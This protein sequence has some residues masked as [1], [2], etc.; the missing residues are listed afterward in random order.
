MFNMTPPQRKKDAKT[1]Q[2]INTLIDIRRNLPAV[3]TLQSQMDNIDENNLGDWY[4]SASELKTSIDRSAGEEIQTAKYLCAKMNTVEAEKDRA[5][6]Q[7][8]QSRE[9][10]YKMTGGQKVVDRKSEHRTV[11]MIECMIQQHGHSVMAD[12]FAKALGGH[13]RSPSLP[14]A[15]VPDEIVA[16]LHGVE[17]VMPNHSDDW[18]VDKV[19]ELIQEAAA[20]IGE[21][22]L[23]NLAIQKRLQCA[24]GD[25][26]YQSNAM[27]TK[28]PAVIDLCSSPPPQRHRGPSSE[29]RGF[30]P[31]S[32]SPNN[33]SETMQPKPEEG[34]I[35]SSDEPEVEDDLSEDSWTQIQLTFERERSANLVRKMNKLQLQILSDNI[36]DTHPDDTMLDELS[37]EIGLAQGGFDME[38]RPHFHTGSATD[39]PLVALGHYFN[40]FPLRPVR[41]NISQYLQVLCTRVDHGEIDDID[42]RRATMEVEM[43][44]LG[45]NIPRILK[46]G[47]GE[48]HGDIAK[49]LWYMERAIR[50]VYPHQLGFVALMINVVFLTQAMEK[51]YLWNSLYE[52]IV[53]G[54]FGHPYREWNALHRVIFA[55][56]LSIGPTKQA[57]GKELGLSPEQW[58]RIKNLAEAIRYCRFTSIVRLLNHDAVREFIDLEATDMTPSLLVTGGVSPRNIVILRTGAVR[59]N[60]SEQ[61]YLWVHSGGR[62]Y[63]S[64]NGFKLT[65]MPNGAAPT[66]KIYISPVTSA[67]NFQWVYIPLDTA[68]AS[69]PFVDY[70]EEYYCTDVEAVVNQGIQQLSGIKP[71]TD[72]SDIYSEE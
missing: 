5:V 23:E 64:A 38:Q 27:V 61:E 52:S 14:P 4:E 51:Y 56:W 26:G 28:R 30:S 47:A 63:F 37:K 8:R 13:E 55:Y 68:P 20:R 42:K 33:A 57:L 31:T 67:E 39:P 21:L 72:N 46:E 24:L 12:I 19:C 18:S 2:V 25:K 17:K 1:V 22:S 48:L 3:S 58:R 53:E 59:S 60:T 54:N 16:T 29:P 62:I 71:D 66:G 49:L 43:M 32:P 70:M 7:T 36:Y 44:W 35:N 34:D 45:V 9:R 40:D 41:V 6:E 65:A 15:Q 11:K 50:D 69:Q 10:T